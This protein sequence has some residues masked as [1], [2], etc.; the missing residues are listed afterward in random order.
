MPGLLPAQ[1]ACRVCDVA[2]DGRSGLV[3]RTV[4]NLELDDDLNPVGSAAPGQRLHVRATFPTTAY[5]FA[6]GHRIRLAIGSSYWP[7]IWPSDHS[8]RLKIST[9]GATL[10]FPLQ[11]EAS[12]PLDRQFPPVR[13]LPAAKGPR[14]RSEGQLHR[15]FADDSGTWLS[16]VWH[17]PAVTIEFKDIDVEFTFETT[18]EFSCGVED[19]SQASCSVEHKIEI[20][21]PDGHVSIANRVSLFNSPSGTRT[22]AGISVMWNDVAVATLESDT[23]ELL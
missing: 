22:R 11:P 6:A 18:A 1:L 21:R 8:A 16:N 2:P 10:N 4:V 23:S 12:R 9:C 14:T 15:R 20:R 5:R 3:T 7:L 19:A 17:Q 13:D